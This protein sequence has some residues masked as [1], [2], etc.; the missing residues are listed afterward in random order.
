MIISG[1]LKTELRNQTFRFR[2]TRMKTL[3]K[4]KNLAIPWYLLYF[5]DKNQEKRI[6]KTVPA[7]KNIVIHIVVYYRLF[8]YQ[9]FHEFF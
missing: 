8:D 9:L 3:S 7:C 6:I 2:S 4:A 1:E 5:I